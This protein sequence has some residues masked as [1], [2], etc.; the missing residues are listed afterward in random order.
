[1]SKIFRIKAQNKKFGTDNESQN[2]GNDLSM[3]AM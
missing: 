2:T 3:N 1:M